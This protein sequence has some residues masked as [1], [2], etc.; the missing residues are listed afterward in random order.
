M[1]ICPVGASLI[2]VDRETDR[3]MDGHD[4]AAFFVTVQMYVQ[5]LQEVLGEEH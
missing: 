4:K 3:W 5:R 2:C 1:D